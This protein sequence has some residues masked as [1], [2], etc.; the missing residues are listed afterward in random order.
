MKRLTPNDLFARAFAFEEAAE[1]LE[2][3]WTDNKTERKQGEF[4]SNLLRRH[5]KKTREMA[6]ELEKQ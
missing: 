1:H 5:A 2:L 3:A 6:H 4:V